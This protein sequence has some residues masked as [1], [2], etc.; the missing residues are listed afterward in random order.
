MSNVVVFCPFTLFLDKKCAKITTIQGDL[1]YRQPLTSFMLRTLLLCNVTAP[2]RLRIA[3]SY[4]CESPV[5]R[6]FCEGWVK[7]NQFVIPKSVLLTRVGNLRICTIVIVLLICM[8][9]FVKPVYLRFQ[10]RRR[11]FLE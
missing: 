11:A 4:H 6:L 8:Y 5:I 1:P 9:V 10:A 2:R 7:A 3:C